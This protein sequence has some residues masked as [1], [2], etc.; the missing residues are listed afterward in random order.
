MNIELPI[1]GYRKGKR[2]SCESDIIP[3]DRTPP[4]SNAFVQKLR[5]FRNSYGLGKCRYFQNIIF[6]W[7]C[8]LR[9]SLIRLSD[10]AECRY[11]IMQLSF[12]PAIS[13]WRQNRGSL[14]IRTSEQNI[15]RYSSLC[16]MLL[17]YFQFI[18]FATNEN[19]QGMI[20]R[21]HL[22]FSIVVIK[23]RY[24]KMSFFYFFLTIQ[25]ATSKLHLSFLSSSNCL[26]KK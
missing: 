21:M 8:L 18:P 20:F 26:S 24:N 10:T 14:V 13:K 16:G 12:S 6:A 25:K 5:G 1:N 9:G 23:I 2:D 7:M 15:F 4:C 22:M 11:I 17:V 19:T 3:P